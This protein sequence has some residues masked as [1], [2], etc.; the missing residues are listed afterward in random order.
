MARAIE[1][2]TSAG[3]NPP[4]LRLSRTLHARRQA[5]FMAWSSA[6]HV[7][8][9]FA[10]GK[11]IV[12]HARVEMRVGGPFELTMRLPEG[13]EHRVRGVF[14]EIIPDVRLVIDMRVTDGDGAPLLRARTELDFS[15]VLG[16][17]RLDVV[18]TYAIED[19]VVAA[20][21]VAGAA[22]GWRA[23]LDQLEAELIRDQ[24]GV[25]VN[26]RSV[27]HATFHL[28]RTYDA[29]RS[30]VWRALTD[31]A[32]KAK[33][34]GGPPGGWELI[35]RHMDVREGGTERLKGRWETSVVST[36]DATYHDVVPEERLVYS[37]VMRMGEKKI[38]VSLATM[39]LKSQDRRTTLLLTEQ[40]AF[41]D[42]YDD[43]GSR[44][45]GTAL[46]LDAL[47][48]SLLD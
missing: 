17:T 38:S 45:T 46:L 25:D 37:Y 32:A 41:L 6:E 40:G 42:G 2:T 14:V 8:R 20:S 7:R 28:E 47:G 11:A 23:T 39:Q 34:F 13:V 35:E 12:P 27:T 10:P 31:P 36:Y 9:W 26:E 22:E 5:V 4:P 44:E 16:G 1:T 19:P 18:Q 15:D 48:A 3:A 33:W 21:M 24:G 30:R 43:A 29:T